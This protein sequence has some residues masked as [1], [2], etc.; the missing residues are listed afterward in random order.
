MS[1]P[2]DFI[3][4]TNVKYL[5]CYHAEQRCYY[6]RLHLCWFCSVSWI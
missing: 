1:T 2:Q 4:Q 3:I 5:Q 6:F